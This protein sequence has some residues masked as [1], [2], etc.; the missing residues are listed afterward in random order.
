MDLSQKF[1]TNHPNAKLLSIDSS[2]AEV[3]DLLRGLG[4][5][6]GEEKVLAL[7]KPGE[8][9]MNLVLRVKTNRRSFIIKQSRPW[10][11]KY[12]QV[13]APS[14]RIEVEHAYYQAIHN[15]NTLQ[16]FTPALL[17][18]HQ[19]H[20]LLGL[21][22]LGAGSDYTRIYEKEQVLQTDELE[23]LLLFI[24]HQHKLNVGAF[25]ENRSMKILNHLHI[26]S[27]P[28]QENN[29][30]NLESVQPGLS[31]IAL[32][33]QRD[34]ELKTM[35]E[36]LGNAY[37]AKGEILIHGDYYPGSWLKVEDGVKVIDPEFGFPGH[38]EFDLAVMIAHLKLASQPVEVIQQVLVD[39]Q[40]PSVFDIAL[41]AGFCGVEIMRR[42]LGLA[43]LPLSL[44]L[45]E[46][47]LLLQEAEQLI[48]QP[49][50]SALLQLVAR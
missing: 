32:K 16:K 36:K 37:L 47:K 26:F 35:I 43:Q 41:F 30:F 10:V 23:S 15:D 11:Q 42:M 1:K 40:H 6:T 3:D 38:A 13:E 39:Y 31:E 27:F 5:L 19:D 18:Y 48:L 44:S 33:Y 8:G 4:T 2:P 20:L 46:K 49:D 34:P 24:N 25:P 50:H 9:N 17:F 22:D 7:E 14:E 45:E 28:F 12:P 29:G 21:E